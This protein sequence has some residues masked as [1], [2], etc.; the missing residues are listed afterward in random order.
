MGDKA[1]IGRLEVY[2]VAKNQ[3]MARTIV[4][5]R[6]PE[7][8]PDRTTEVLRFERVGRER[9]SRVIKNVADVK[10]NPVR[11]VLKTSVIQGFYTPIFLSERHHFTPGEV[12]VVE[13]HYLTDALPR[14]RE[15]P[16]R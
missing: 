3:G 14:Y 13:V 12:R 2:V 4:Q 11:S 9:G 10:P 16:R 15:E 7:H 5:Y 8:D 6:I 1:G